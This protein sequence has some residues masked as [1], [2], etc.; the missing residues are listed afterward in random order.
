MGVSTEDH[1]ELQ[2]ELQR[3]RAAMAE[4][5]RKLGGVVTRLQA[6]GG[7]GAELSVMREV[8]EALRA[9][10]RS[11]EGDDTDDETPVE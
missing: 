2:G 11:P 4:A 3:L 7:L 5:G 1:Q 9:E 8:A 6:T 10:G